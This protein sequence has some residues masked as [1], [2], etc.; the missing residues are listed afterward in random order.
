MSLEGMS[1]EEIKRLQEALIEKLAELGGNSGNKN[2]IEKLKWK[3]DIYWA[4]RNRLIDL[5]QLRRYRARGGAVARVSAAIENGP[6]AVDAAEQAQAPVDQAP[7]ANERGLYEEIVSV[8]KGP[9]AL[10][11]RFDNVI[12]EITASQGR[13]NTG[14]IWT[15]PDVIVAAMR[16]F[17]YLPGKYFDLVTFEVKQRS[18]FNVTGVYEALAHR[19]AATQSYLWI[20]CSDPNERETELLDRIVEEAERHGIGVIVAGKASDYETWDQRCDA[21]RV[22]PD[23]EVLNEFITLQVS[24]GAKEELAKWVR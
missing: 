14:G 19:R 1:D 18:A 24:D 10:E 22:E 16:I 20:E 3:N 12:V 21:R 13:R 23:P 9:W 7:Q 8:L 6:G 11:N 17:R 4:I 5:G 2:L 15:R